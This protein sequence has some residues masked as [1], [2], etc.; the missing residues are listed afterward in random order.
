[1]RASETKVTIQRVDE[2]D[3]E[4]IVTILFKAFAE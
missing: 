2:A 1:V 3:A 4:A